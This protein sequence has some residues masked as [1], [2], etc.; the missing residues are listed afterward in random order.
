MTETKRKQLNGG[1]V[2]KSRKG[3]KQ[4]TGSAFPV[5]PGMTGIFLSC[6]RSMV[7]KAVMEAYD[8]FNEVIN[9]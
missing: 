7:S 9:N 4:R 8:L 1:S 3:K 6:N 2:E 5:Q